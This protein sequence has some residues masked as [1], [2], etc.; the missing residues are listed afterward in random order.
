M[1]EQ[2]M[3]LERVVRVTKEDIDNIICSALEDGINYWC[4]NVKVIG[5]YL[6]E[7]V[8]EQISRGGRLLLHDLEEEQELL[9]TKEK[10][11]DGLMKYL[12]KPKYSD[13]LKYIDCEFHLDFRYVDAEVADL[14][15]QLALFDDVIYGQ[16]VVLL[17]KSAELIKQTYNMLEKEA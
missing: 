8:H 9:L 14:I 5:N 6:G 4:D 16:M 11:L 7:Y 12:K 1:T 15:I 13:I 10:F 2:R 17:R 3:H